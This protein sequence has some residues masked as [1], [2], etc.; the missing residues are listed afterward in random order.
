M[1]AQKVQ[2]ALNDQMNAELYSAHLYL[3][4]AAYFESVN[5]SGMAQ[6]MLAQAREETEHGLKFFKYINDRNGRVELG[7]I[8]A[9]QKDWKTP[10][11]VFEDAYAHEQKVTAKIA[12]LVDLAAGAK[13]HA[14]TVFLNWFVSEQVEEEAGVLRIIERIKLA[15]DAPG[16]LFMIDRELAART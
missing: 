9:P 7:G 6:W 14:T 16:A 8:D 15:K 11:A 13:D 3:S 4:M 10:L 2:D 1:L 12:A 5:L